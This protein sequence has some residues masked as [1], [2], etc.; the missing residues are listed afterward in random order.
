MSFGQPTI[1]ILDQQITEDTIYGQARVDNNIT[2]S[3]DIQVTI[4]V[5]VNAQLP[6]GTQIGGDTRIFES[7][8]EF[9]LGPGDSRVIEEEV[10]HGVPSGTGIE[11]CFEFGDNTILT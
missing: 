1:T 4:F 5:D 10:Q 7:L 2:S 8:R 9:T 3:I 6:D 11:M